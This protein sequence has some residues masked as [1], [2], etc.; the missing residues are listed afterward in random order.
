M[1]RDGLEEDL[2]GLH[3]LSEGEEERRAL[4]GHV[5]ELVVGGNAVGE[6]HQ[7][8]N[9]ARGELGHAVGVLLGDDL[10]GTDD[11][12]ALNVIHDLEVS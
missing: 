6:D 12:V 5:E 2:D 10:K 9:H 4:R 7:A 3:R 1:L 8:L 11:I